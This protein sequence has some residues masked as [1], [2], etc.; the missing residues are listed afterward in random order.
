MIIGALFIIIQFGYYPWVP[1]FWVPNPHGYPRV[2]PKKTQNFEL[3]GYPTRKYPWNSDTNPTQPI[4]KIWF[5]S[6]YYPWVPEFWVPNPHP[7]LDALSNQKILNGCLRIWNGV[8]FQL[9]L[10]VEAN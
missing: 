5:G 6:G 3:Y 9:L 1:E 7:S 8:P 10:E 4:P 2:I